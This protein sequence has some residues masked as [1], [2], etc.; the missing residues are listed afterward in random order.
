M[1]QRHEPLLSFVCP[2]HQSLDWRIKSEETCPHCIN[3]LSLLGI[4]NISR[5]TVTLII[6]NTSVKYSPN[7]LVKLW[8][9]PWM[10]YP[11]CGL[12]PASQSGRDILTSRPACH[13]PQ[14]L[15]LTIKEKMENGM[16][17]TTMLTL[18]PPHQPMQ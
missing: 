7:I 6:S 10:A 11:C 3:K 5:C 12:L 17:K 16:K 9:I 4:P 18:L 1:N 15:R 13:L 14:L 8:F 2:S